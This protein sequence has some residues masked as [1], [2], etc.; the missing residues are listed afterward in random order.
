MVPRREVGAEC[1][2]K[3]LPSG[4]GS[5]DIQAAQLFVINSAEQLGPLLFGT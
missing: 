1:F 5:E 2:L 4:A 3:K